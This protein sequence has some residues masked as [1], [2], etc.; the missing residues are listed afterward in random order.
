[1]R[2]Y[3]GLLVTIENGSYSNGY[4]DIENGVITGFGSPE[5]APN[6]A[7]EMCCL[8]NPM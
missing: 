8:K 6:Y 3:N 2:I 1:M 5:H 4:V 7:G